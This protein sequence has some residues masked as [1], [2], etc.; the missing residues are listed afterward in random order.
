VRG[1]SGSGRL[2]SLV[3]PSPSRA[4]RGGRDTSDPGPRSVDTGVV[5]LR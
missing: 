3:K 5:G 1:V 2:A 4:R